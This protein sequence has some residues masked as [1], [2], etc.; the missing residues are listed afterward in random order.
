MREIRFRA[1]DEELQVMSNPF[2]LGDLQ[3]HEDFTFNT[4]DGEAC[5]GYNEFGLDNPKHI[6]EQYTGLKDK[7][8]VEIY[9]GDIC[10]IIKV[11]IVDM[12]D[13]NP[14]RR[15]I[16]WNNRKGGFD[17]F[18]ID[19]KEGGSGWSFLQSTV[20]KYYEVIGDIHQH[21]ELL[22]A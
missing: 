7:N 8:G 18:R 21:P 22:E 6:L 15:I 3:N 5:C 13:P 11:G 9:E 4:P 16:K 14:Y 12:D 1:W 2:T 10:S 19:G 17:H 20:E